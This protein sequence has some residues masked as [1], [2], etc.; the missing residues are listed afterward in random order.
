MHTTYHYN[1]YWSEWPS[2]SSTICPNWQGCLNN[3]YPGGQFWFYWWPASKWCTSHIASKS[4]RYIKWI[5]ADV[6]L[7]CFSEHAYNEIQGN[8][9][10]W[11]LLFLDCTTVLSHQLLVNT[12]DL[13]LLA[14]T[15]V[16]LR[17]SALLD[18]TNA[19]ISSH[20]AVRNRSSL[21]LYPSYPII[22][23]TFTLFLSIIYLIPFQFDAIQHYLSASHHPHVQD[24]PGPDVIF[25]FIHLGWLF[26]FDWGFI[27]L[28]HKSRPF[29]SVPY[30]SCLSMKGRCAFFFYFDICTWLPFDIFLIRTSPV[31]SLDYKISVVQWIKILSSMCTDHPF[32]FSL[33]SCVF[34]I[35]V[36]SFISG[37]RSW[38]DLFHLIITS[39]FLLWV[40]EAHHQMYIPISFYLYFIFQPSFLLLFWIRFIQVSLHHSR[41]F[42]VLC[43]QTH[44]LF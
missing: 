21:W 41:L 27:S 3:R 29:C 10:D 39:S 32:L 30:G 14:D 23:L 43:S 20:L 12:I 11:F 35:V 7:V 2:T 19:V 40:S 28:C 17:D 33:Q 31:H 15:M 37:P 22:P 8:T 25:I 4:C 1:I 24:L 42:Y 26:W 34:V 44:Q 5:I 9:N 13:S 18:E 36:I 16:S 38:P 6:L